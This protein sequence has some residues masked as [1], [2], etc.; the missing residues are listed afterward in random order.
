MG[1]KTNRLK[2]ILVALSVLSLAGGANAG[3]YTMRVP[4]SGLKAPAPTVTP[5]SYSTYVTTLLH[6]DDTV[7][8]TTI[9][10][11][12]GGTYVMSPSNTGSG[13]VAGSGAKFGAGYLDL[14]SGYVSAPAAANNFGNQDFTIEMFYRYPKLAN[15]NKSSILMQANSGA[16][17]W[18]LGFIN[19]YGA[20]PYTMAMFLGRWNYYNSGAVVP[21]DTNW[22]HLALSR[23]KNVLYLFL[24]GN[25]V[26]SG[27][28]TGTYTNPVFYIGSPDTLNYQGLQYDEIRITTGVGRY[29]ANFTPPTAPFANP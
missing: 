1:A 27:G 21:A 13:V 28:G 5:D 11:Q 26:W 23:A 17:S 6:F 22:H 10:D 15:Y 18:T 3:A 8:S 20:R 25:M 4:L 24:D 7:G 2:R 14:S 12:Q 29:S 9:S 16:Q 19:G